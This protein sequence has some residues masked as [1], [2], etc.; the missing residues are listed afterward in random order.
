MNL[1]PEKMHPG[2]LALL[3]CFGVYS[4]LVAIAE[5]SDLHSVV[6]PRYIAT[7]TETEWFGRAR[8]PFLNPTTNGMFLSA[9]VFAFAMFWPHCRGLW[10]L[11]VLA[12]MAFALLGVY[13]TLTR[14]CWLGAACGLAIIFFA[15]LS[16]QVRIPA[17]ITS[18]LVVALLVTVGKDSLKSFK[19]DK[20]VSQFDME[21]SAKLRPILAAVAW[22]VIQ[23][24][25]LFGA[26]YGQYKHVDLDYLRDP[27]SD[28]PLERAKG[29][30]Q[31]NLFLSIAVDTGLLGLCT[32]VAL[33][34]AWSWHGWQLW[35]DSRLPLYQRQ[36]GLFLLAVMAQWCING[37]FHD[38]SLPTNS[39]MLLFVTAAVC[40]GVW[41]ERVK[42]QGSRVESQ[43]KV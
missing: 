27:T 38:I 12:G 9:A 35:R 32:Y 17:L 18:C 7:S 1:T 24:H 11:V 40:Q 42:G 26:G 8:G 10:R 43:K 22:R 28:L 23:D 4:S 39:N 19:R 21:Q 13:C 25:P 2:I 33:L 31:H 6:F 34:A 15:S 5:V 3:A 29:Y 16:R 14:S 36:I 20:N 41:K 30:V 37:M